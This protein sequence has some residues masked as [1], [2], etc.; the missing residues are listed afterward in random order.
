[1]SAIVNKLKDLPSQIS[2]P[3]KMPLQMVPGGNPSPR[4]PSNNRVKV[5]A[6]MIVAGL[7]VI[8]YRQYQRHSPK[9]VKVTAT[10]QLADA[11][12]LIQQANWEEASKFLEAWVKDHPKDVT[13]MINYALVL[14]ERKEYSAAEIQL[15][16]A[17]E[18]QAG[19]AVAHNNLGVVYGAMG[20]WKNAIE[21]LERAISLNSQYP[22]P[23]FN[24]AAVYEKAGKLEQAIQYYRQY[25]LQLSQESEVR[26]ALQVRVRKLHALSVYAG[27]S[28]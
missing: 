25:S 14:K 16:K 10:P 2:S 9:P 27:G 7:A 11:N 28:Q 22:D 19:S 12:P 26:K 5:M 15:N 23:I 3:G 6:C 4:K 17:L 21:E 18:L 13:A 8:G 24:L 20:K 1:M